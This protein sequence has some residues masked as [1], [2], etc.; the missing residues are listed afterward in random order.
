MPNAGAT[1]WKRSAPFQELFSFLGAGAQETDYSPNGQSGSRQRT[2]DLLSESATSCF[3]LHLLSLAACLL[4]CL[5][6]A[7]VCN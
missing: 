1:A 2:S 4:L 5:L 7:V 6:S 3:F